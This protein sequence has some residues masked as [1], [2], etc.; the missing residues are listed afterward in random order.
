MALEEPIRR[1]ESARTELTKAAGRAQGWVDSQRGDFDRQR[2]EP[3]LGAGAKLSVALTKAAER[4]AAAEKL[5]K[6]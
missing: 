4:L 1:A 5:L 3:M 2:L 6:H